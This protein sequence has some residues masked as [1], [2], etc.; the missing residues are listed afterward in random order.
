MESGF[1][2]VRE[3]LYGHG[4]QSDLSNVPAEVKKFFPLVDLEHPNFSDLTSPYLVYGEDF[5]AIYEDIYTLVGGRSGYGFERSKLGHYYTD[6]HAIGV[7]DSPQL[8]PR[9][10]KNGDT[11]GYN[12][13]IWP[14]NLTTKPAAY[15]AEEIPF[16]VAV[17]RKEV[18]SRGQNEMAPVVLIS[19][20]YTSNRFGEVS[21]FSAYFAQ[22]GLATLGIECPSHGLNLSATE[23]RLAEGLLS[24]RGVRQFGEAALTDRAFDQNNDGFKDSGADFWT[25]YVFHTRDMV[26]QCTLTTCNL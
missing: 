16:W 5:A 14:E 18:S 11:L 25:S 21:Q 6:F 2:A 17:P 22:H 7:F 23:R 15:R 1:V 4:L 26:R 8:F 20:G 19:H 24:V 13:Q 9:K 12:Q 3:G 10:D